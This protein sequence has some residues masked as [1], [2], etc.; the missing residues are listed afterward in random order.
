MKT[1]ISVLA[2]GLCACGDNARAI[3]APPPPPMPDL[4]LVGAQMDGTV[5]VDDVMFGSD[6]CEI[7]D[8][9]IGAA[10]TRHLLHFA[11]VVENAGNADL[12]LG[13][14]PAAGVSSGVFVWS[15]CHM[16]HNVMGYADFDLRDGTG[17]VVATGA[18]Q[19]FCLEDDEQ[20]SPIGPSHNFNC[21]KQGI[22]PGWADVYSNQL[23]CQ[24]IDVTGIAPGT[25]T[26]HVVV[27]KTGVL[28]DADPSNNEW[29]TAVTFVGCPSNVRFDTVTTW[30]DSLSASCWSRVAA[31]SASA[32]F[33]ATRIRLHPTAVRPTVHT[34]RRWFEPDGG[35]EARL[36]VAP[37]AFQVNASQVN[38]IAVAADDAGFAMFAA[39][40]TGALSG[41]AYAFSDTTLASAG[42]PVAI[43]TGVTG[44][45]GATTTVGG[46]R[47]LAS[48]DGMPT[49]T[50]TSIFAF[51]GTLGASAAPSVRANQLAAELPIATSA[52]GT[53]AFLTQDATTGEVDAHRI[54]ADGTDSGATTMIV[55]GGAA[56]M[57]VSIQP[58][59]GGFVVGYASA[60]GTVQATFVMVD[61]NLAVTG[62][63]VAVDN[64]SNDEYRPRIAFA[65]GV[66][67][68]AWLEKNAT[69]DDDVW[70]QIRDSNLTLLS[71]PTK[72][73]TFSDD[74]VVAAD[75]NG[76]W[77]AWETYSPDNVLGG[78]HV[79]TD[80]SVTATRIAMSGGT[81]G[82]WAMTSRAGQA[83]LAWTEV[84]GSG[85][86]FYLD[87]MCP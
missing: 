28:P 25:Y 5:R 87:P 17:A 41:R 4:T 38:A 23:S 3:D 60:A 58:A 56:A 84:G 37:P 12:S 45:L 16:K 15:D 32:I 42:D 68:I 34:A 9:C 22:S 55:P 51:D 73:A 74:V 47:V 1:R 39:D 13:P 57:N 48:L 67:L 86:D 11:A 76:F 61:D 59:P 2:V 78:A 7:V 30:G 18:K 44:S 75:D 52:A 21:S 49:A 29:M 35:A 24:W 80:G 85:P 66:Y 10:G 6:A 82:A 81:P 63:A 46:G 53:V 33:P 50:G 14:V 83:V 8:G 36:R 26:L 70:F 40:S 79:G 54:A 65:Q 62:P 31:G 43:D 69:D 72:I 77:L 20:V 19:A 27:D 71:G 64:A